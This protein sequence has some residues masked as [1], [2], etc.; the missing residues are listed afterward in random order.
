MRASLP[1]S[2]RAWQIAGQREAVLGHSIFAV[3]RQGSG[4]LLIALH[5][6][7]SSSYDWRAVLSALGDRA[8]L[9]P[10]FLGFGLSDKPR[11][12][13]YSLMLQA[14]IV[15]SLLRGERGPV[16]LVAHDMGTSVASELLARD[17]ERRLSFDLSA[18]LL[19]NGSMILALASLTWAQRALRSRAGPLVAS[20]SHRRAFE[21]QFG[22]LFSEAHPL[23][24]EEAHA[25]WA[26]W[27]RAGGARMAHRLV[28]Y[29]GEREVHASRWHGAIRDWEGPLSL[30][31]G[32]R[33]PV[34]TPR[35]LRGLRTLRPHAP[36]TEL[37][38]LGHYPQI[39]APG[40]IAELIAG[41]APRPAGHPAR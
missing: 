26:L 34:C 16:V 37:A 15:E 38:Q 32:M 27:A 25:Q 2:V 35:V 5:G 20:L 36:V 4:P 9:A 8:A 19:L 22:A 24:P 12:V 17:L 13:T 7:P 30:A 21:R 40:V 33:D 10:D 3:R 11:A 29:L 41:V 28:H 23:E 39:E 6:F 1:D 18:V 31:W 14:D